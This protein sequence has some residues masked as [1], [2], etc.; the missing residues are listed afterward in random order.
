MIPEWANASVYGEL[1][2]GSRR[3]YQEM[4]SGEK[5][6]RLRGG[7]LLAEILGRAR[8]KANCLSSNS[9][10]C[11]W[12]AQLKYYAY[13]GVSDHGYPCGRDEYKDELSTT[14]RWQRCWGL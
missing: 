11:Q 8:A 4:W 3:I 7:P 10:T 6:A 13:S 12:L 2:A 14:R 5:V 1:A 9:S